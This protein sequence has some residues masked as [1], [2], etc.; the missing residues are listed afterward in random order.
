[1]EKV[2]AQIQTNLQTI[3]RKAVDA[4]AL[5][6]TYQQE[7]KGKHAAIFAADA[8]FTTQ[9]K[10]FEPYVAETC[11]LLDEL[12]QMQTGYADQTALTKKL[13]LI[14]NQ[15]ELLHSTLSQFKS[16]LKD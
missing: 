11:T 5:I 4:D 6:K 13:Q 9:A 14:V 16:S 2:I 10:T 12:T 8:P 15:I 7:G 1:M 3:Y